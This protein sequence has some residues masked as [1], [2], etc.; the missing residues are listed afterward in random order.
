MPRLAETRRPRRAGEWTEA[1]A[2]TFIVTLAAS[3]SVT[4]AAQ[5]AGMS[6]KAAYHLKRRDAGFAAAWNAA[7]EAAQAIYERPAPNRVEG[8]KVDELYEPRGNARE[9]YNN[10]RSLDQVMDR[11][12]LEIFFSTIANR[13]DGSCFRL[14]SNGRFGRMKDKVAPQTALP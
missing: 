14:R 9:G 4:F 8:D 11:Q 5:R 2:V 13:A 7:L 10:L 6:R 12:M 3:R 1:K